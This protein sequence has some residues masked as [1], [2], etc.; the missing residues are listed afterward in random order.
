MWLIYRS[1]QN[2]IANASP[3]TIAAMNPNNTTDISPDMVK[4]ASNM[5]GKMSPDELQR[6]FEMA[7]S[8]ER[9][10]PSSTGSPFNTNNSFKANLIPPNVTPDMLKTATDMMGK[11]SPEELQNMFEMASN[12]RGNNSTQSA[13]ISANGSRFSSRES[14]VTEANT[15]G[16]ASSRGSVSNSSS[17]AFPSSFPATT[18]DMQEQMRNQMKDPATRQVCHC[19]HYRSSPYIKLLF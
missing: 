11:M 15:E 2:F 13:G 18:A 10:N 3:E 6:M 9:G 16:E 17:T 19:I 4:T 1:F 12:L 14:S 8:F 7:S 5:I